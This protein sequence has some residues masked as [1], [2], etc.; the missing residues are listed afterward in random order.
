MSFSE[1][2]K[3]IINNC[4]IQDI[5]QQ[6]KLPNKMEHSNMQYM[7][8]KMNNC[9]CNFEGNLVCTILHEFIHTHGDKL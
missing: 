2:M 5:R 4:I 8:R 9:E 6:H 1:Q 7:N 3:Q